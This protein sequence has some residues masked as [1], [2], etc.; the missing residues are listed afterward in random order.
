MGERGKEKERE[1]E[2]TVYASAHRSKFPEARVTN[3]VMNLSTQA[4]GTEVKPFAR[5][6][7]P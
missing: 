4:L 7:H 2:L 1:G 5:E 3:R 6:V